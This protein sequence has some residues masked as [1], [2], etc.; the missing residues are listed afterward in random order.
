MRHRVRIIV[1]QDLDRSSFRRLELIIWFV[2]SLVDDAVA[3]AIIG[4]LMG[5]MYPI[6]M[7]HC[8]RIFPRWLLTGAIGWIAGSGQ[9]GSALVPFTAGAIASKAGIA[10]LQPL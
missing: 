7:N 1:D 8:G 2:P 3:V 6:A 4:V 9:A 10:T 5:P